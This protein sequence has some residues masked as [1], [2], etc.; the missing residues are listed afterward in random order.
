MKPPS[1]SLAPRSAVLAHVLPFLAWL[2]IMMAP[3]ENLPWRYAAQTAVTACLLLW[4]RPWRFYPA[5]TVRHLPAAAGAGALVFA[6][7][8]VMEL[9]WIYD[10]PWLN[11]LYL[12]YG[13]R[14]FGVITGMDAVHPY[15]PESCGWPLAL[16]RL[17]GSAFVI[18]AAEEFFWRGFLYRWMVNR[19]F[20]SVPERPVHIWIFL[21]TALLFGL[22]HD[23][24][25]VGI[26]AG[27]GYGGLY[28]RTRSI[29]SAV[30]AHMITNLLLGLYVL[31][32]GSYHFW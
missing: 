30:A 7:W 13:I 29:G 19:E 11:D 25:L 1:P 23:R 14:P 4:L 27:L 6:V 5:F 10:F 8:I 18:A 28:L 31:A 20:L 22:E 26:L 3:T 16:V 32:T 24:W 17:A 15:A 2:G 12:R 21:A 9:P